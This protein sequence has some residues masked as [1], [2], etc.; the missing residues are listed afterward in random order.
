MVL[1]GRKNA[2]KLEDDVFCLTEE[3]NY[4]QSKYLEQISEITALQRDLNNAK[5]E[6]QKLRQEVISSYSRNKEDGDD[7]TLTTRLTMEE[8]NTELRQQV[9]IGSSSASLEQAAVSAAAAAMVSAEPVPPEAASASVPAPVPAVPT[10]TAAT[11]PPS[12]STTEPTESLLDHDSDS[13]SAE[14]DEDEHST[15]SSSS[16]EEEEIDEKKKLRM[17]AER[18]LQWA[19]YRSSISRRESLNN[20]S[21]SVAS[22]KNT[23]VPRTIQSTSLNEEVDEEEMSMQ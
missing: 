18:L 17:D 15:S 20:G 2:K 3:R 14:E 6:I 5:R 4:F 10:T 7:S 8:A 22:S 16:S 1:L 21:S 11:L 13:E 9:S 12:S 19:D 23:G